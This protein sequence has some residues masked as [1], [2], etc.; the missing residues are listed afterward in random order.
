L[1]YW[2]YN[3]LYEKEQIQKEEQYYLLMHSVMVSGGPY[4]TGY[5]KIIEDVYETYDKID[6]HFTEDG[7]PET[8]EEVVEE[9]SEMLKIVG[10]IN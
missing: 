8:E 1:L 4:P 3:L 5:K 7:R 10:D 6:K 2:F 9:L